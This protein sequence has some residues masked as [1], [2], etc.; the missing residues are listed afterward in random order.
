[1]TTKYAKEHER[2]KRPMIGSISFALTILPTIMSAK[3]TIRSARQAELAFNFAV[4][5]RGDCPMRRLW[6]SRVLFDQIDGTA[7][8]IKSP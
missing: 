7:A 8:A 6:N 5:R 4:P 3:I 2:E 1:M